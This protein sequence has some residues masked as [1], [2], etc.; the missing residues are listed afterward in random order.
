MT[1]L[2]ARGG[3][4]HGRASVEGKTAAEADLLFILADV[5]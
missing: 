5:S 1:Q 2:S 3:K 4:G